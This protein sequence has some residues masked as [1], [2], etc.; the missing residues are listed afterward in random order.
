MHRYLLPS[1]GSLLVILKEI[2]SVCR[3]CVLVRYGTDQH[4][5]NLSEG[6]DVLVK[7]CSDV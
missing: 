7:C 4:M 1:K 6:P 3:L 2:S 5:Y